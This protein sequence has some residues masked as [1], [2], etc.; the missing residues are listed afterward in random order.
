MRARAEPRHEGGVGRLALGGEL[1]ADRHTIVV[2][3][4]DGEVSDV[5]FCDWG[6]VPPGRRNLLR[7]EP[8]CGNPNS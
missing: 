5:V 8:R 1:V 4:N 7:A 2:R 6:V 3:V